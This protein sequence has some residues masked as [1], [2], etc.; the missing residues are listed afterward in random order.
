VCAALQPGAKTRCKKNDT[1]PTVTVDLLA[2]VSL[3]LVNADLAHPLLARLQSRV[4]VILFNPPYVP[5]VPDEA[6]TSQ[7]ERDIGGAWAGGANGTQV[8]D[9]FI[10]QVAE[11][12]SPDGRFYLVAVAQNNI[13][14]IQRRMQEDYSLASQGHITAPGWPRVSLSDMLYKS[15]EG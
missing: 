14:A 2:Q 15:L 11:L 6:S 7:T 13:P 4:D 10:P 3:D 5:T 8:T 12:L 1:L 9:F